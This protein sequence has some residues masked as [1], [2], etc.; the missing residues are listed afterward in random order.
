M[1]ITLRHLYYMSLVA[2]TGSFR[3]AAEAAGVSQPVISDQIAAIESHYGVKLF[4][5]RQAGARPSTLGWDYIQSADRILCEFER[6]EERVKSGAEGHY[7]TLSVGYYK[8][9]ANGALRAAFRSM[10]RY[11]PDV[12][13]LPVVA[14]LDDL[15]RV[16]RNGAL[17]LAVLATEAGGYDDLRLLPLWSD[18]VVAALPEHHP[19]TERDHLYWTDLLGEKFLFS[20]HD[21]GPDLAD[22][23]TA[24]LASPGRRPEIDIMEVNREDVLNFVGIGA[25]VSLQCESAIVPGIGVAF[26]E[27]REGTMVSRV[28]YSACW[29]ED[30]DNPALN[31][32]LEILRNGSRHE[33]DG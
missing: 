28:G 12:R 25:G 23:L 4:E 5:R 6:M 18:R 22:M 11:Y 14:G 31:V 1:I 2:R 8:S 26:R 16:V 10:I 33:L 32:F 20:R 27:V 7:G 21:P 30:N 29:R 13:L 19:L 17:D 24:K 9:L 15:E 3:S